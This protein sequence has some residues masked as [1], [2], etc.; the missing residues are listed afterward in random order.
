MLDGGVVTLVDR[1]GEEVVAFKGKGGERAEVVG[2]DL[3]GRGCEVEPLE[4]DEAHGAVQ[5]LL[6]R[7]AEVWAAAESL[8]LGYNELLAVGG[9]CTSWRGTRR[10][11]SNR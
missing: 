4:R 11:A 7:A 8:A 3:R 2:D 1:H 6:R 9:Y 5:G 10:S